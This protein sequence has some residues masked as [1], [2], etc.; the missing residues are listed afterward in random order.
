MP[1]SGLGSG[2][3]PGNFCRRFWRFRKKGGV[4]TSQAASSWRLAG[5]AQ[6][7][8]SSCPLTVGYLPVAACKF[9]PGAPAAV[10][11]ET[12]APVQLQILCEAGGAG[13]HGGDAPTRGWHATSGKVLKGEGPGR[14]GR[15]RGEPGLSCRRSEGAWSACS[16]VVS[17][18]RLVG[19]VQCSWGSSWEPL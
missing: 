14:L 12:R 17:P 9:P 15:R 1:R 3:V 18:F 8:P 11:G 13:K 19:A 5:V 16:S 6:L 2:G 10:E 7:C 4:E